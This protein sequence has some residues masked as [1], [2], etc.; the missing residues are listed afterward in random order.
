MISNER[1]SL[2]SANG[3]AGPP[4]SCLASFHIPL[5]VFQDG[6]EYLL[7]YNLSNVSIA[8]ASGSIT[9]HHWSEEPRILLGYMVG[10]SSKSAL[11]STVVQEH[12]LT[13]SVGFP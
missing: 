11:S 10:S 8:S 3:A 12:Y 13:S 7:V 6:L 4:L 1:S 9:S 5:H 2:S